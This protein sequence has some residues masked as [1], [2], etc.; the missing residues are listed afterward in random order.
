MACE[1]GSDEGALITNDRGFEGHAWKGT[2]GRKE[3]RKSILS[4]QM[5]IQ[6]RGVIY[7]ATNKI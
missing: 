1:G 4:I 7:Q 6:G 2:Q 5:G 3:M